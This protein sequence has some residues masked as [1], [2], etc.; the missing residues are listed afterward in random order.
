MAPWPEDGVQA[1]GVLLRTW[2]PED[3]PGRLVLDSDPEV[4]RWSPLTRVP[5]LAWVSERIEQAVQEAA[6]GCPTSFAVVAADEPTRVLGSVDWRNRYP[7]PP[8]SM[9]DIGYGVAAA[10]RRRGVATTAVRLITEWLLSPDG[11][12]V[13]RVQLDHAVENVASCRTALR[14]GFAVEGRRPGY[15]PLRE[16]ESSPVVRHAVCLHGRL[17]TG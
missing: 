1:D 9:V 5:D 7:S 13:H 4:F 8:F 3:V 15:L 14:A 17:R 11:G 16:T 10:A 12:D 6:A 2:R